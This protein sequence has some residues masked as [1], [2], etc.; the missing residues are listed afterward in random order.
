MAQTYCTQTAVTSTTNLSLSSN[1]SSTGFEKINT[2]T[3]Q[4]VP[5]SPIQSN[6]ICSSSHSSTS[7]AEST[8][9]GVLELVSELMQILCS[10][11]LIAAVLIFV[12]S[13]QEQEWYDRWWQLAIIGV[14]GYLGARLLNAWILGLVCLIAL[15]QLAITV[16]SMVV[17]E[18]E[19]F[20]PTIRIVIL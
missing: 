17:E 15:S 3:L 2:I 18:P 13:E 10:F 14:L 11:Y 9:L 8:N 16:Y 6:N 1:L 20:A 5:V 19:T 4:K 12:N 7:F